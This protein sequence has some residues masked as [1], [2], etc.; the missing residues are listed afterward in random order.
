LI[1]EATHAALGSR[2]ALRAT[3]ISKNFGHVAALNDVALAANDGEILAIVGDNGAG[4]STLVKI[5]TGIYRPDEGSISVYGAEVNMQTPADARKAGIGS[6]HQDLALVECLDVATNMFL[7]QI[8]RHGW[9]ADRRRMERESRQALDELGIAIQSVRTPIGLLSGGQRQI[10]AIARALRTGANIVLLDEPTAALGV[11]ET[12]RA[13]EIISGLRDNDRAVII[14]SHDLEL[15]FEIADRVQV[16]RL[17]RV[18]G[19]RTIA[20]TNREEVVAMITGALSD[21][22]PSGGLE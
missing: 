4:K 7:G 22:Q 2:P 18:A 3:H 13:K 8:P 6:V 21:P 17:G 10:V 14:V 15:V 12:G 16:M 9:F 5:I 20:E 1:P 11:R 19:T